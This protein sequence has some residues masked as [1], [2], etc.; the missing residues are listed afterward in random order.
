MKK[1]SDRLKQAR[2]NAGYKSA[3]DFAQ[4]HGIKERTYRSHETGEYQASIET[5]IEYSK[6]LNV[7]PTWLILGNADYAGKNFG[8]ENTK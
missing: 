5:L 4:K 8:A 2:I 7:S 6:I 3:R 1:I